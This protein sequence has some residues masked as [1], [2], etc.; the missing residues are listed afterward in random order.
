MDCRTGEIMPEEEMK[1]RIASI[2]KRFGTEAAEK[3]QSFYKSVP[4]QRTKPKTGRNAPC[5]C[6]SGIKFK[7]CCWLKSA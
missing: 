2:E 4:Y 5:P 1:A 3:E 6:G 7:K